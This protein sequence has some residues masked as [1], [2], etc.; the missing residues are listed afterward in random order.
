M[1]VEPATQGN[2]A[3]DG[4]QAP[5]TATRGLVAVLLVA[6]VAFLLASVP[7]RN[8][9]FWLHLAAGRDL[10]HTGGT[11]FTYLTDAPSIA[12]GWLYD[13]LL[14][15]SFK[16][17]GATTLMVLKAGLATLIGL[18]LMAAGRRNGTTAYW[19]PAAATVLGLVAIG[20]WLA[21]KPVFASYLLFA[22]LLLVLQ[23]VERG[24][25]S[26]RTLIALAI[27][28][29]LWVHID[30]WFVLGLLLLI[31]F[32]LGQ[33]PQNGFS[34]GRA[35]HETH[36]AARPTTLALLILFS[37]GACLL[38]PNLAAVFRPGGEWAISGVAGQ[39]R[40]DPMLEMEILAPWR[41]IYFSRQLFFTGPGVAFWLLVGLSLW[42]FT[43][44]GES[45]RERASRAIIWGVF[46]LLSLF[47][48]QVI[49][50]FAMTAC[51][52]FSWQVSAW[53]A[54]RPRL[55]IRGAALARGG[56]VLAG[57]ALMAGAWIGL[58]QSS[59]LEPRGWY[60]D[61]D[62]GMER[63]ASRLAQW[64]RQGHMP[65]NSFHLAPEAANQLAW[66]CTEEKSF[67]SSQL[68]VS[69]REASEFVA[70]RAGLL[71]RPDSEK[72]DWREILRKREIGYVVAYSNNLAEVERVVAHLLRMPGEWP[73]LYLGGGAAVF[74]WRDPQLGKGANPDPAELDRTLAKFAYDPRE[75][76]PAPAAGPERGPEPFR[77]WE[78]FWKRRPFRTVDLREAVL[79]VAAF[80]AATPARQARNV[81][82]WRSSLS[83]SLLGHAAGPGLPFLHLSG[84]LGRTLF[85]KG[86]D[87]APPEALHLAVRAGRRAVASDPSE[88]GTHLVLGEAF[89]RLHTATRERAWSDAL[90]SLGRIRSIQMVNSFQNALRLD[91]NL[92]TA[93]DRLAH[94][95]ISMDY[96]D[97]ALKH[98]KE[99]LRCVRRQGPMPGEG[100][101]ALEKRLAR[102]ERIL[103]NLSR[104]VEQMT[105]RF[106]I[107]S[108]KLKVY[109]RASLAGRL[110][111]VGKALDILLESD[112]S[113]FG[114]EG[115]DLELKLLL[116]TGNTEYVRLWM[117][118]EHERI[119]DAYR[120]NKIQLHA[121]LGDFALA[122]A[123]L[124]ALERLRVL[125]RED[126]TLQG[127]AALMLANGVLA[128]TWGGPFSKMPLSVFVAVGALPLSTYKLFPDQAEVGLGL[129]MVADGL[130][131]QA[132]LT[133]VRGMLAM[134]SGFVEQA[135]RNFRPAL[136]LLDS[137]SAAL[138][139]ADLES[140]W[141]RDLAI[142]GLAKLASARSAREPA[143]LTP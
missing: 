47:Q 6:I 111:L 95:F 27:L 124:Q 12:N 105:Q 93:H 113:A 101:D 96:K 129:L 110:G 108:S 135:E 40:A 79:A 23:R 53:I 34:R 3:V 50:F 83:A 35:S 16:L 128:P 42:S 11:S 85:L 67:L 22:I 1:T 25:A 126:L 121:S 136:A 115:M 51:V 139:K 84:D 125:D 120:W 69:P 7:V 133:A 131:R 36:G 142:S 100:L 49:P 39:L 30:G 48:S 119:L 18:T 41:E 103:K 137:S 89:Y 68:R 29:T 26:R 55:P 92:V 97:L 38:N 9:D 114:V 88:A 5:P 45:W 76:R 80:D 33:L 52:S 31:C 57:L 77:W 104:S 28:F 107:N 118:E 44:A 74:G 102:P 8:S 56:L 37:A 19:V 82:V 61:A 60:V 81:T 32:C 87:S 72:T 63:L 78:A 112:V 116:L 132:K 90:A 43:L 54:E 130:H 70:V 71:A 21:L 59:V 64:R 94:L 2:F 62:P 65:R 73:L 75:A 134:E 91:P 4:E 24:G 99:Y 46:L 141:A 117:S 106:E 138:F 143:V 123:E 140:F 13:V 122:D 14:Y 66:W 86:Q 58:F 15:G 109:D 98:L 17:L 127:A 20:P 10:V